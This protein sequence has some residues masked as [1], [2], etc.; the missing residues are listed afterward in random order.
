MKALFDN[1]GCIGFDGVMDFVAA[2]RA[3]SVAHV[4]TTDKTKMP[5]ITTQWQL[6]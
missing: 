6:N 2:C 5:I 1:W 4:N 3:R